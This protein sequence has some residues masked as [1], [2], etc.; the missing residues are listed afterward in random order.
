[1]AIIRSLC[2]Y[3]IVM[4]AGRLLAEGYPEKVLSEKIVLEAYL[5]E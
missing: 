3:L 5:G 4:D 1:M 2:D